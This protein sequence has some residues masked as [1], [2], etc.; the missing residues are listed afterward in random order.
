MGCQRW[1]WAIRNMFGLKLR[2]RACSWAV[3]APG[4]KALVLAPGDRG[5]LLGVGL[6]GLGAVLVPRRRRQHQAELLVVSLVH[7]L[8]APLL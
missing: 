3:C 5:E 8:L 4:V 2:V 1:E 6:D 7:V